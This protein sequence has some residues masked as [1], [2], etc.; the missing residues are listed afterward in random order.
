MM[1]TNTKT[2]G[3]AESKGK[4]HEVAGTGKPRDK[5]PIQDPG[6]RYGRS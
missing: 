5:I 3:G 1:A 4:G 2:T 6:R